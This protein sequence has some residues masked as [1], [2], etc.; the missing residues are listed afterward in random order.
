EGRK[1]NN[2]S[3]RDLIQDLHHVYR[4]ITR[5]ESGLSE[6]L[7]TVIE[8]SSRDNVNECDEGKHAGILRRERGKVPREVLWNIPE[9]V[10]P[11]RSDQ[12]LKRTHL[13]TAEVDRSEC[14]EE[15][16]ARQAAQRTRGCPRIRNWSL[17]KVC[18]RNPE[19]SFFY[20]N[21]GAGTGKSHLINCIY[22]EASKILCKTA[23]T[24]PRRLTYRIQTV[25]LTAF[26]VSGTNTALSPEAAE[27]P[28]ASMS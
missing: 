14:V 3:S 19:Q 28:E 16:E 27:K 11:Y 18:G 25:P 1:N 17:N 26:H 6:Y 13:P 23:E 20:I 8:N 21:G 5:K 4:Y 22:S 7:K 15:L 24:C 12:E 10:C 9:T 2:R